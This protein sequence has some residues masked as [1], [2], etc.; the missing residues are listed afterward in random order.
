ME[1]NTNTTS[2]W[3]PPTIAAPA[4]GYKMNN[5]KWVTA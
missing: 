1:N 4:V 5:L 2:N 3:A